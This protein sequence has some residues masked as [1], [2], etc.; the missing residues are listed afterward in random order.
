MKNRRRMKL[1][2]QTR[3]TRADERLANGRSPTEQLAAL[4]KRLGVGKGAVRE[5]AR[6]AKLIGDKAATA[7]EPKKVKKTKAK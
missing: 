2:R 7:S 6:L 5:R 3:K 1:S 4:D